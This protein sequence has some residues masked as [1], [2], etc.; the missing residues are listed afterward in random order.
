MMEW[1][2]Y[3]RGRVIAEHPTGFLII[4][5]EGYEA[6]NNVFC[7]VCGS[8]M[9]GPLDDESMNKFNCCDSCSTFWAYPNKE[10]WKEGWR[11]TAEEVI[12][13]YSVRHI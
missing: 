6:I 4:K 7:P 13:K 2:Q 11:P 10:R 8:V 5:P 3:T 12:N 1:K 9:G